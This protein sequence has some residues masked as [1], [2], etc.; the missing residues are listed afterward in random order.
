MRGYPGAM[1]SWP[2]FV[3]AVALGPF[4]WLAGAICFDFVH[5]VLHAMLRSR[6]CI[7]RALA[8]PHAVH[9]EWIDRQ[10]RVRWEN[11]GRNIACHIVPEYLTQLVFTA[12]VAWLLPWPF[13][14]VLA[15]LQTGVF[16]AIL[17]QRGLDQ[18]FRQCHVAAL[19]GQ[20]HKI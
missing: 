18:R 16:V 17:S 9:H 11:Q 8:W 20:Q 10:L 14:V 15:L 6:W 4:L 1:P 13:A 5:G 7:V 19:L 12:G 2:T 3:L